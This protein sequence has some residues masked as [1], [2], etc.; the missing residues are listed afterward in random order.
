MNLTNSN[1]MLKTVVLS[2][3]SALF[4]YGASAQAAE[5]Q[6]IAKDAATKDMKAPAD[7]DFTKLDVNADGKVSLKESVKDKSLA[8]SFD[9]VDANKDGSVTADEYA[10]YKAAKSM[11]SAAPTAAAPA[12]VPAKY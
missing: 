2:T 1:L 3:L 5:S 8:G 12:E 4:F 11:D 9:A 7:A 10:G 6:V